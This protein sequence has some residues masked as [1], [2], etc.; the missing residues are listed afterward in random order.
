MNF[1]ARFRGSES[2]EL[3]SFERKADD[4]KGVENSGRQEF[5]FG[6]VLANGDRFVNF[7]LLLESVANRRVVFR[8][9]N[10]REL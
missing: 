7:H 2:K 3:L 8:F 6:E 9:I 10:S 4:E 5:S 1:V